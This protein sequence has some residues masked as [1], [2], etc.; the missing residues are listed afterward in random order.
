VVLKLVQSEPSQI[1]RSCSACVT[2]FQ[3]KHMSHQ[4]GMYNG[5]PA[6]EPVINLSDVHVMISTRA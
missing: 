4:E 2:V 3:F 1:E 6:S 5:Q